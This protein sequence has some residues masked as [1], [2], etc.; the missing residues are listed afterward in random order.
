MRTI[1]CVT[2]DFTDQSRPAF[3]LRPATACYCILAG[4]CFPHPSFVP[5]VSST[6][7]AS[8]LCVNIIS[9]KESLWVWVWE[10]VGQDNGRKGDRVMIWD[11]LCH[12]A[13]TPILILSECAKFY[14]NLKI[15]KKKIQ[16]LFHQF[17][18]YYTHTQTHTHRHTGT[19]TQTPGVS[20]IDALLMDTAL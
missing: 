2:I 16:K 18:Q 19:H 12:P 4:P 8:I 10:W 1:R 17:N 13:T 15:G 11:I 5:F 20:D 7:P 14:S 3:S 6:R 9:E